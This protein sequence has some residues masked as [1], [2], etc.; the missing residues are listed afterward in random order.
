M[1]KTAA[2]LVAPLFACQMVSAGSVG[3][4]SAQTGTDDASV[5]TVSWGDTN[6]ING[7]DGNA[8][9]CTLNPTQTGHYLLATNFGFTI[10]GTGIIRGIQ[11]DVY[12]HGSSAVAQVADHRVRIIK[13]GSIG[14]EDKSAGN[15]PLTEGDAAYASY[16]GGTDLWGQTWTP[17]DINSS[18]FGFAIAPTVVGGVEVTTAQIDDIR[19]TVYGD[20]FLQSQHW[21]V[22]EIF[23]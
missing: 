11:V 12:R 1:I 13:G 18:S 6:D 2:F 21:Q 23:D 3:P 10:R 15:W 9:N 8:A 22:E 4:R 17:A 14:T 5:G 7:L 19:I 16:G 20:G